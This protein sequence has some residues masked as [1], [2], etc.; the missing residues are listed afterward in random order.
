MKTQQI[1][2]TFPKNISSRFLLLVAI[3][4]LLLAARTTNAQYRAGL[5][6]APSTRRSAHH[7]PIAQRIVTK[8]AGGSLII[9]AW[10]LV[11]PDET[12]RSK[13]SV[14]TI[15]LS[16]RG[17]APGAAATIARVDDKHGNVLPAYAEMGKPTYPTP[18]QVDELNHKSALGPPETTHLYHGSLELRLE[19]NTLALIRIAAR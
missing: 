5:C 19:P 3:V 13:A 11:D 9:A 8:S 6:S 1:S 14:H 2:S 16:V 18:A 15:T 12:S 4:Y 17:V 10:N 7:E